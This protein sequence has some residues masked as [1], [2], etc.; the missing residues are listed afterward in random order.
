VRASRRT[1]LLAA[2]I[3]VWGMAVAGGAMHLWGYAQ[4]PGDAGRA[5]GDWRADSALRHTPGRTAIVMALHPHCPCSDASVEALSRLLTWRR[6][7]ADADVFVLLVKPPDAPDGWD[8]TRLARR[9]SAIPGI[10][11]IKDEGGHEAHRFAAETSGQ[12]VAYDGDGRL[13]FAGGV[14]PARGHAGDC[15]GLD[16]LRALV[17][18][19]PAAV[20]TAGPHANPGPTAASTVAARTPVYGC[21]LFNE[22]RLPAPGSN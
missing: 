3:A 16:V 6:S 20:P 13:V 8:E 2:V 5:P 15:A 12:A 10:T 14:T 19:P 11:V 7:P 21:P 4:R 18:P 1:V 9:V 17:A 22:C